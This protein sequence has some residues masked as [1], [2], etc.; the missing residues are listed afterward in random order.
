[1]AQSAKHLSIPAPRVASTPV[2]RELLGYVASTGANAQDLVARAGVPHT[3]KALLDPKWNG[4]LLRREFSALYA[5]AAW[6]LDA[7]AARQENRSPLTKPEFDLLC[8]C[9]IT[10][11]TLR[12][13]IARA[14]L[15]EAMLAPRM[16]ILEISENQGIAEFRMKTFRSIKNVNSYVSD[17]TGL[18]TH[19][20]L[21]SWLIGEDIRLNAVNFS[22]PRLVSREC[23]SRL[24]LHPV[25]HNAAENALRFS[26]RYLDLPVIRSAAELERLLRSFPFD[27]EEI[28]SKEASLS[29]KIRVVYHSALSCGAP[30]PN[31]ADIARQFHISTATLKR[32][33][34]EEGLT[35]RE[36]Q[37]ACRS[38][39]ACTLLEDAAIPVGDVAQ[40]TGFSDTTAFNRAFQ[41]WKGCS[42][43]AW[44]QKTNPPSDYVHLG[45]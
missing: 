32:R 12:E 14:T 25:I 6:A 42:P 30:I 36:L 44:R 34:A 23:A 29:E 26:S 45:F 19:Y 28:L 39:L 40:W 10:C 38:D 11:R 8:Q 33:L 9:L 1:M 27:L 5:E 4:Q 17:L 7:E 35:L 43:H 31:G 16:G 18:S 24:M 3:A 2:A 37:N 41:R 15:F 21:F 22:Y 20:R 13:V